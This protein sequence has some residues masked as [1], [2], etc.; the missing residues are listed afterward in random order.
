MGSLLV[1]VQLL[2]SDGFFNIVL[3]I[4]FSF[5]FLISWHCV[6]LIMA[7]PLSFMTTYLYFNDSY[8]SALRPQNYS[9]LPTEIRT[10]CV[11]ICRLV[12]AHVCTR[13]QDKCSCCCS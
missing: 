4:S 11:L 1:I 10:T 8:F 2:H 7:L 3:S 12:S 13:K 9:C 5:C 6:I